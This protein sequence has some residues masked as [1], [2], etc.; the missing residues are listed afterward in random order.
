MT[1][2]AAGHEAVGLD[3]SQEFVAMGRSHSQCEVFHQDFLAMQL[4]KSRFD[5][6]NQGGT[7]KAA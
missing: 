7:T 4:P 3:G 6:P 2:T 5:G 1:G